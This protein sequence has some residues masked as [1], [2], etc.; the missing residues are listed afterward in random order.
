MCVVWR[1]RT[2][3]GT[4]LQLLLLYPRLVAADALLLCRSFWVQYAN[5]LTT[6]LRSI[7]ISYQY[8]RE[9]NVVSTLILLNKRLLYLRTDTVGGV[10]RSKI[11]IHSKVCVVYEN[12]DDDNNN[13]R[14][15]V[16]ALHN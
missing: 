9:Y 10:S 16:D 1:Q 8:V 7:L 14:E 6:T 13:N 3:A 4:T 15:V 12:D 5:Q 11:Y 2:T